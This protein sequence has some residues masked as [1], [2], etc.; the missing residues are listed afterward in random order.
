[1]GSKQSTEQKRA[2]KTVVFIGHRS[3]KTCLI[4]RFVEEKY[5]PQYSKNEIECYSKEITLGDK[6]LSLEIIETSGDDAD[7]QP[8]YRRIQ[9]ANL[10]FLV[11]AITSRPSYSCLPQFLREIKQIQKQEEKDPTIILVG[12]KTDLEE[13]RQISY[14]EALEFAEKEEIPYIEVSAKSGDGV[15]DMYDSLIRGGA[16]NR[17]NVK[18]AR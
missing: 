10:F 17:K 4:Q 13:E 3:G 6:V 16:V 11:F 5:I 9:E 2:D 8:R 12:N 15:E 18:R 14:E 1:M 7:A